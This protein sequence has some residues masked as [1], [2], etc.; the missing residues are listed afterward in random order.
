[1]APPADGSCCKGPGYASPADAMAKGPREKLVYVP[2]IQTVEGRKDYLATVCVDPDSPDYSKVVHR[3]PMPMRMM[4]CITQAGI[5]VPVAME[6]RNQ[7]E[8]SSFSLALV[9]AVSTSLT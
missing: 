5:L 2:C 4:S 6:T 3:L 9:L 7:P 8:T 1:M